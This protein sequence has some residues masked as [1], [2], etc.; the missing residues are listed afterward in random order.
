MCS[1]TLIYIVICSS[2]TCRSRRQV[3][4]SVGHVTNVTMP[5]VSWS[6]QFGETNISVDVA[7]TLRNSFDIETGALISRL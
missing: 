7:R 2:N 5:T 4:N 6:R 3:T 1:A